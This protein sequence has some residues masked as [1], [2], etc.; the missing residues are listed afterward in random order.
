[1]TTAIIAI[2]LFVL[3]IFSANAYFKTRLQLHNLRDKIK[4]ERKIVSLPLA[5]TRQ[6]VKELLRR[7]TVRFI[8]LLPHDNNDNNGLSVEIHSSNIPPPMALGMLK[9]TYQGVR[10]SINGH[11][12]GEDGMDTED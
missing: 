11:E 10:N 1:M 4:K 6:I 12:N 2:I 3:L 9:A 5:T 8:L 7:P